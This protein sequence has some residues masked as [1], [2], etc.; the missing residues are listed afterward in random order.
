MYNVLDVAKYIITKYWNQGH[1]ITNLK[2]QKILYYV[3]GYA[4]KR[5]NE[6]A[7]AEKLYK[8]PYGPVVPEV[9]YEY[10]RFRSNEIAEQQEDEVGAAIVQIKKDSAMKAIIDAVVEKSFCFSA[11]DLVTMTH[12]EDPW[13]NA[14][15]G[16]V[17]ER[18]VVAKYFDM[19]DPLSLEGAP[20]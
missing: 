4:L 17:I 3:Q 9:Y 19:N 8:W 2:L 13:K 6:P 16:G 12:K 14:K 20:S 15:D 18:S 1:V 11:P 10:N 7:F 5:C